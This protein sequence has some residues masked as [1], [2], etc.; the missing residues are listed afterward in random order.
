M[1]GAS[2]AKASGGALS[3]PADALFDAMDADGN[4]VIDRAEFLAMAAH[5]QAGGAPSAGPSRR[6][7]QPTAGP[8]PLTSSLFPHGGPTGFPDSPSLA[9]S[10]SEEVPHTMPSGVTG[11]ARSLDKLLVEAQHTVAEIQNA[12]SFLDRARSS[13]IANN[14][15]ASPPQTPPH[16]A[17]HVPARRKP[18]LSPFLPSP[19]M[20]ARA[21]ELFDNLDSN[22]DGVI[23]RNEFIALMNQIPASGGSGKRTGPGGGL[24]AS[25][26]RHPSEEVHQKALSA[27][28]L[29]LAESHRRLME[30]ETPPLAK[31]RS[32]SSSPTERGESRVGFQASA[33]VFTPNSAR[34]VNDVLGSEKANNNRN[35]WGESMPSG[36]AEGEDAWNARISLVTKYQQQLQESQD[37]NRQI[38]DQLKVLGNEAGALRD[39]LWSSELDKAQAEV[40]LEQVQHQVRDHARLQEQTAHDQLLGQQERLETIKSLEQQAAAKHLEKMNLHGALEEHASANR[41]LQAQKDKLEHALR[42][43]RGDVRSLKVVMRWRMNMISSTHQVYAMRMLAQQREKEEREREAREAAELMQRVE[44]ALYEGRQMAGLKQL[45]LILIGISKGV[46]GTALMNMKFNL[47][48][49]KRRVALELQEARNDLRLNAELELMRSNTRFE[50]AIKVISG[51]GLRWLLQ[52]RKNCLYRWRAHVTDW[53]IVQEK[54]SHNA[55]LDAVA[56][57]LGEMQELWASHGESSYQKALKLQELYRAG[58]LDGEEAALAKGA[59][60][61]MLSNLRGSF[62]RWVD[63]AEEMRHCMHCARKVIAT[64]MNSRVT[65]A[66]AKWAETYQH[67]RYTRGCTIKVVQALMNQRL[68]A[69]WSTWEEQHDWLVSCRAKIHNVRMRLL[70][71]DLYRAIMT[72]REEGSGAERERKAMKILYRLANMQLYRGLNDWRSDAREKRETLAMLR[73]VGARIVNIRCVRAM[74]HWRESYYERVAQKALTLRV[75]GMLMQMWESNLLGAWRTWREGSEQDLKTFML[76]R[77]VYAALGMRGLTL[78]FGKWRQ[79]NAAKGAVLEKMKWVGAKIVYGDM[80]RCFTELKELVRIQRAML[81]IGTRIARANETAALQTWRSMLKEALCSHAAMMRVGIMVANKGMFEAWN[82]WREEAEE[83]RRVK[84]VVSRIGMKIVNGQSHRAWL[85]WSQFASEMVDQQQRLRVSITRLVKSAMLGAFRSWREF[86][87]QQCVEKDKLIRASARILHARESSAFRVWRSVTQ[88]QL[89]V[90]VLAKKVMNRIV[91]A[92]LYESLTSWHSVSQEASS[93]K[94]KMVRASALILHGKEANAWRSWREAYLEN[95]AVK[96]LARRIMNRVVNSAL[97]EVVHRWREVSAERNADK[98]KL[99]AASRRIVFAKEHAAWSFWRELYE[100]DKVCQAKAK[101]ALHRLLNIALINNFEAW[102]KGS[103]AQTA[104]ANLLAR[105]GTRLALNRESAAMIQWRSHAEEMIHSKQASTAAITRLLQRELSGSWER[106]QEY[107]E[108]RINS[109]TVLRRAGARLL[110]MHIYVMLRHWRSEAVVIR[111]EKAGARQAIHRLIMASRIAAMSS[112][113]EW[114]AD[115]KQARMVAGKLIRMKEV[116]AL[117]HWRNQAIEIHHERALIKKVMASLM[118][119]GLTGAI[120]SWRIFAVE[121]AR[122]SANRARSANFL[123][124]HEMMCGWS[125]WRDTH[126]EGND[127]R[128]AIKGLLNGQL[129]CAWLSWG[130]MAQEAIRQKGLMQRLAVSITNRGIKGALA[131]W[132][133]FAIEMKRQVYLLRRVGAVVVNRAISQ[134]YNLWK[135]IQSE[136]DAMKRAIGRLLTCYQSNALQAWREEA[137][138]LIADKRRMTQMMS[139][140]VNQ[141]MAQGYA[142]WKETAFQAKHDQQVLVRASCQILNM[143]VAGA[144]RCWHDEYTQNAKEM[145]IAQRIFNRVVNSALNSAFRSWL[146]TANEAVVERMILIRASKRILQAREAAA[147]RL[148]LET[149]RERVSVMQFAAKVFGRLVNSSLVGAVLSWRDFARQAAADRETLL[150]AS[151]RILHAREAAALRLWHEFYTEQETLKVVVTRVVHRFVHIA[152]TQAFCKWQELAVQDVAD[153][154]LLMRVSGAILHAKESAAFRFWYERYQD[155]CHAREATT[156]VLRR[157][158]NSALIGAYHTWRA[159]A[160]QQKY[161]RELLVRVL[162]KVLNVKLLGAFRCWRELSRREG[163]SKDN[164]RKVINRLLN[165]KL[166]GAFLRW[167]EMVH[168]ALH[169]QA[170]MT[171]ALKK[172]LNASLASG[173]RQWREMAGAEKL[174]KQKLTSVIARLLNSALAGAW[175]RWREFAT[176]QR[177]QKDI[178]AR[179]STRILHA[180]EVACFQ[181]WSEKAE[182]GRRQ[183]EVARRAMS[184]LVNSAT[185]ATMDHWRTTASLTSSSKHKLVRAS[186]LILHSREASCWRAWRESYIEDLRCRG[187]VSRVL[188][189]VVNNA[190]IAALRTWQTGA[191]QSEAEKELLTRASRHILFAKESSAWRVWREIYIENISAIEKC[192]AVIRRLFNAK[193]VGSFELWRTLGAASSRQAELMQRVGGR[194]K[195]QGQLAAW[196]QWHST[197]MEMVY[198]RNATVAALTRLFQRGMSM[199][200]EQW[201]EYAKKRIWSFG[202]LRRVGA[203]LLTQHLYMYWLHWRTDAGSGAIA[204]RAAKKAI[205]RLVMASQ[206]KVIT[207]WRDWLSEFNN[208]KRI[209]HRLSRMKELHALRHWHEESQGMTG[210]KQLMRNV[211]ASLFQ[212]SLV[213]GMHTWQTWARE[214]H[215][216]EVALKRAFNFIFRQGLDRAWSV[217]RYGYSEMCFSK[218]AQIRGVTMYARTF[219]AKQLEVFETF[220]QMLHEHKLVAR[221]LSGFFSSCRIEMLRDAMRVLRD[222]TEDQLSAENKARRVISWFLGR[223]Y[224]GTF[225]TWYEWAMEQKRERAACGQCMAHWHS[226]EAAKCLETWKREAH[227]GRIT[228]EATKK[229]MGMNAKNSLILWRLAR[230]NDANL[231]RLCQIFGATVLDPRGLATAFKT[232]RSFGRMGGEKEKQLLL[233]MMDQLLGRKI[234]KMFKRWQYKYYK[235]VRSHV[236]S[237]RRFLNLSMMSVRKAWNKLRDFHSEMQGADRILEKVLRTL[238]SGKSGAAFRKLQ[239]VAYNH[240]IAHKMIT[241]LTKRGKRMALQKWRETCDTMTCAKELTVKLWT[242]WRDQRHHFAI[243]HRCISGA[244]DRRHRY[245]HAVSMLLNFGLFKGFENWRKSVALSNKLWHGQWGKAMVQGMQHLMHWRSRCRKKSEIEVLTQ[246]AFAMSAHREAERCFRKMRLLTRMRLRLVQVAGFALESWNG[247]SSNQYFF[248]LREFA[249]RRRVARKALE[250]FCSSQKIAFRNLFMYARHKKAVQRGMDLSMRK[251]RMQEASA[252]VRTLL[253]TV[254]SPEKAGRSVQM[255]KVLMN[256]RANY[257]HSRTDQMFHQLNKDGMQSRGASAIT[258]CLNGVSAGG[259]ERDARMRFGMLR[260]IEMTWHARHARL[261]GDLRTSRNANAASSEEMMACNSQLERA[262]AE[263]HEVQR[264]RRAQVDKVDRM[265]TEMEMLC[266]LAYR[267]DERTGALAMTHASMEL[268][269]SQ[270]QTAV[271]HV[272]EQLHKLSIMN[273]ALNEQSVPRGGSEQRYASV[274]RP[275]PIYEMQQQ[276]YQVMPVYGTASSSRVVIP[277]NQLSSEYLPV[278]SRGRY[279]AQGE[280]G[281]LLGRSSSP[282]RPQPT[283]PPATRP[284]PMSAAGVAGVEADADFDAMD[285]N[286]DGVIS[287]E[288]F[289]AIMQLRARPRVAAAQR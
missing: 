155:E 220:R 132:Y 55:E 185:H 190:M 114:L 162:K 265:H 110:S 88:D 117:R 140:I 196:L 178:V 14:A 62:N 143:K 219:M 119:S 163:D 146:Q 153:R 25:A 170:K 197:A 20:A 71:M 64:V 123:I 133:D 184:H 281:F 152:Q 243:W 108:N 34:Y 164:A 252:N 124:N 204:L 8:A 284:D 139:R 206:V 171:V 260:W 120:H 262:N 195:Y 35:D 122:E 113:R 167:R 264:A 54:D 4:G 93:N 81:R 186:A 51:S 58:M 44:A 181:H 212:S 270:K 202:I 233:K 235:T 191:A 207:Q 121:N 23:D 277:Q 187:L 188:G 73:R 213:A 250:A 209:A 221:L 19:G 103:V 95:V 229:L 85:R 137:Q 175:R 29:R 13:V 94:D 259:W 251:S 141:G 111:E 156:K 36:G 32:R 282:P 169:L 43:G 22:G 227:V 75:G 112:W 222:H 266:K 205:T 231:E 237:S 98:A 217:W 40:D 230:K 203:R 109:F 47:G 50:S 67:N 52:D 257:E 147:L 74:V 5:L 234:R 80:A 26:G 37:E 49:E 148:W 21:D 129:K 192:Q 100:D 11:A 157:I 226:I 254:G 63:L 194:I 39:A 177:Y 53:R 77:R 27:L 57:R 136:G 218:D 82:T 66:W 31:R 48:D 158:L 189:M 199:A 285:V 269:L 268:E 87:M 24:R 12:G 33:A 89:A 280:P 107:Y 10:D 249:K 273:A 246:A 289:R 258:A 151:S 253:Y 105:V 96:H 272:R 239:A 183:L 179:A 86:A 130:E 248:M 41:K 263:L 131:Q 288:E 68:T 161:E 115:L 261:H 102:H 104:T 134:A 99:V 65:S 256:F 232:L 198:S 145:E 9:V 78:C 176:E 97:V 79:D 193:L 228:L 287:R 3:H 7:T 245:R 224:D 172:I 238:T 215:E 135:E 142:S 160:G 283:P 16:P 271:G 286:G 91:N 46:R 165:A 83:R 38:R 201:Q 2:A 168:D 174:L 200:F 211:V 274:P 70:L 166:S 1:R 255:T 15:K 84:A 76:M 150:I 244:K 223:K 275:A 60:M 118:Q 276:P 138:Q 241:N 116:G 56:G 144:L 28:N 125:Y 240:R 42:R 208:A 242:G 18:E 149:H 126:K 216:H 159:F 247:F 173:F 72:W 59:A 210:D 278:G 214:R 92:A 127:M 69:A 17:Q 279:G 90:M 267:V 6:E 154:V 30:R 61:F 182:E 101:K 128:R 225:A 236:G 45:Q 106:W 180:K